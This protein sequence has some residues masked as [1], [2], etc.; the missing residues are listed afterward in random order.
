MNNF[1]P[2]YLRLL[3]LWSAV[4]FTLTFLYNGKYELPIGLSIVEVVNMYFAKQK[5][6]TAEIF[7]LQGVEQS[8]EGLSQSANDNYD[9]AIEIYPAYARA[10]YSRA[11]LKDKQSLF[12]EAIGDY[13]KAIELAEQQGNFFSEMFL[14]FLPEYSF[15]KRKFAPSTAYYYR[16]KSKI[17]SGNLEGLKAELKQLETMIGEETLGNLYVEASLYTLLNNS[18]AATEYYSLKAVEKE[19]YQ[20]RSYLICALVLQGKVADAEAY[21]SQYYGSSWDDKF[22]IG[23]VVFKTLTAY[24]TGK[25]DEDLAIKEKQ[26]L[27]TDEEKSKV[28]S[29]LAYIKEHKYYKFGLVK[30][31]PKPK[32]KSENPCNIRNEATYRGS[33]YITLYNQQGNVFEFSGIIARAAVNGKIRVKGKELVIIKSSNARGKLTIING[34]NKMVGTLSV[35]QHIWSNEAVS[36]SL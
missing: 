5:E 28:K 27:L 30:P 36:F 13:D 6:K 29:F 23:D 10:Y 25:K 15:T 19:V 22:T 4:S 26:I 31:P 32:K 2:N 17:Q 24:Y 14:Q 12:E 3:L 16:V 1:L 9:K 7:Y 33:G 8:V 21:L 35:Y 18:Y 20:A 11:R 34:C